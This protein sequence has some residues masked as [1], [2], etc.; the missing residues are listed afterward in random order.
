MTGS[1]PRRSALYAPASSARML[2]KL[3]RVEADA[4]II[5]LEDSVAPDLKPEARALACA[6]V[7]RRDFGP[8]EVAIR[9]N[10]PA[11]G[12]FADDLAAAGAAGP[13]ALLLSKVESPADITDADHR[14]D[15]LGVPASIRLWAMIETP[16]GLIN[17]REIARLAS[18]GG[19]RRLAGLVL[20]TNDIAKDTG[21]IPGPDRVPLVP[22][23]MEAVL[24][25]RAYGLFVLDGVFNAFT[26]GEGFERE[27]LQGRRLGLDGKT[28]IHPSQIAGANRI[29]A[30][31][32]EEI[33]EA[34]AIINAFAQE[35]NRAKGAI[36]LDG[37]MVELLHARSAER[38]LA[39]E[40][41][42]RERESAVDSGI[43][44]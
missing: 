22:W 43:G 18:N 3:R 39:M 44:G 8:R 1:R 34:R 20:G 27:C 10:A 31:N 37:R 42:I 14:L 4:V 16:L 7:A 15:A 26:D 19:S 28:L 9:L 11:T 23:L 2:E 6:A 17:V 35:E 32:P 30:P 41:A 40:A 36:R 24:A 29:F 33:A 25:A 13:N 38:L 5:D 12:W 21:V